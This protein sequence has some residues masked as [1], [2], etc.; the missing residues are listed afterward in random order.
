MH[1]A[2]VMQNTYTNKLTIFR[3]VGRGRRAPE[4]RKER[5]RNGCKPELLQAFIQSAAYAHHHFGFPSRTPPHVIGAGARRPLRHRGS[6]NRRGCLLLA[7][8]CL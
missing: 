6:K 2:K 1:L 4:I 3:R 7:T 5:K 8:K